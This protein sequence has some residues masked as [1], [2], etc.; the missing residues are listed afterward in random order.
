MLTRHHR[1]V[2]DSNQEESLD[3][4]RPWVVQEVQYHTIVAETT[5]RLSHDKEKINTRPWNKLI[6]LGH[7]M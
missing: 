6:Q 1:C 2:C 7:I 3:T 4:L 5:H